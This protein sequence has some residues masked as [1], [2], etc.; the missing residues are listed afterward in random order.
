MLGK[1]KTTISFKQVGPVLKT[2]FCAQLYTGY[3]SFETELCCFP[4]QPWIPD[5]SWIQ[6]K[7]FLKLTVQ[8]FLVWVFGVHYHLFK[9]LDS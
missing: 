8:R 4:L 6:E 7:T 5:V 3:K 1:E 2:I 9:D